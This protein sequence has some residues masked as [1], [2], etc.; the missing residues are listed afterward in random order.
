MSLNR[1]EQHWNDEPFAGVVS[2]KLHLPNVIITRHGAQDQDHFSITTFAF[3]NLTKDL[4]TFRKLGS[5]LYYSPETWYEKCRYLEIKASKSELEI[6]CEVSVSG[7]T[8]ARCSQRP[9]G[10]KVFCSMT[11]VQSFSRDSSFFLT[12]IAKLVITF[13]YNMSSFLPMYFTECRLKVLFGIPAI[14]HWVA[15]YISKNTRCFETRESGASK[16]TILVSIGNLELFLRKNFKRY[17]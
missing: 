8:S 13:T 17:F 3:K 7:A 9:M 12:K 5:E 2:R 16:T 10:Q 4:K 15:I 6:E 14:V 11:Q 1:H